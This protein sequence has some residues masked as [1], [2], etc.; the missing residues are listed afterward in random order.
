MVVRALFS[1]PCLA[2][3]EIYIQYKYIT[4]HVSKYIPFLTVL[5]S[6]CELNLGMLLAGV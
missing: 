6:S 3:S 5:T 2:D 1:V 4:L